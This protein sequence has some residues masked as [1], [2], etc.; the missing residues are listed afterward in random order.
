[1]INDLYL[2]N[3]IKINLQI[4][5]HQITRVVIDLRH[6]T[7]LCHFVKRMIVEYG[8]RHATFQ[9]LKTPIIPL[10]GIFGDLALFYT[11]MAF[12]PVPK[13]FLQPFHGVK[14]HELFSSVFSSHHHILPCD[15]QS[16]HFVL[17]GWHRPTYWCHAI[18]HF[19]QNALSTREP[20]V[21][22]LF[23]FQ[24]IANR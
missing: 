18:P 15:L 9:A 1:M 11:G 24:W 2:I 23:L 8:Y 16:S 3:I 21:P 10:L 13:G 7:F 6:T 20:H 4:P 12:F 19:C 17:F 22:G 14:G 5:Q